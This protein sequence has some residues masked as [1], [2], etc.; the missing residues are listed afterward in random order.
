M[1][2][3]VSPHIIKYTDGI[4]VCVYF[5]QL[6]IPVQNIDAP[7]IIGGEV[8]YISTDCFNCC[9]V[10]RPFLGRTNGCKKEK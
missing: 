10:I 1:H 3:A 7:E 5:L 8:N 4:T 9:K 2:Q 6:V